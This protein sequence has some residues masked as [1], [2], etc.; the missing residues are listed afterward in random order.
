MEIPKEIE[1]TR[2]L[3]SSFNVFFREAD[4]W[5]NIERRD[6]YLQYVDSFLEMMSHEFR[7]DSKELP[8]YDE[9][10]NVISKW[11]SSLEKQEF[12]ES[13]GGGNLPWWHPEGDIEKNHEIV[14][15]LHLEK[16]AFDEFELESDGRFFCKCESPDVRRKIFSTFP[17]EML[18][19]VYCASKNIEW[20]PD[21][22]PK[23]RIS[24]EPEFESFLKR[25]LADSHLHQGVAIL[26]PKLFL[27][28]IRGIAPPPGF[29]TGTSRQAGN[30]DFAVPIIS[31]GATKMRIAPL[32]LACKVV[33]Q[34]LLLHADPN[35]NR[36]NSNLS[37]FWRE[38]DYPVL[39]HNNS[40]SSFWKNC[41]DYAMALGM[42]SKQSS[43]LVDYA[44]IRWKRLLKNSWIP[45]NKD[46]AFFKE[47]N[48]FGYLW[49]FM[50]RHVMKNPND[51]LLQYHYRQ[52]TRIVC[53]THLFFQHREGFYE[54]ERVRT[55]N[56]ALLDCVSLP[57][58]PSCYHPTAN[59]YTKM[60]LES[61]SKTENLKYAQLRMTLSTETPYSRSK[62]PQRSRPVVRYNALKT[63]LLSTL[64]SYKEYLS[65][66]CKKLDSKLDSN[67]IHIFSKPPVIG[68]F[69]IHFIR[70]KNNGVP[71]K[72]QKAD[73]VSLKK[74][75]AHPFGQLWQTSMKLA[76]I[77]I[78]Q[79]SLRCFFNRIDVAG[80]EDSMPNWVFSLVLREFNDRV[81]HSIGGSRVLDSNTRFPPLRFM[82]HAGEHFTSSIQGLRR[83]W[84]V[85]E[86]F[87]NIEFIGHALALS[88]ERYPREMPV[89]EYFD[90]ILW[91]LNILKEYCQE[92]TDLVSR[93]EAEVAKIYYEI[94]NNKKCP[95]DFH[96]L[97]EAYRARF[98]RDKMTQLGI[99]KE[100]THQKQRRYEYNYSGKMLNQEYHDNLNY[101]KGYIQ[102][103][104]RQSLIW[105]PEMEKPYPISKEFERDCLRPA[106]QNLVQV[107]K[108]KIKEKRIIIEHCP[109]SNLLVGHLGTYENHPIFDLDRPDGSGLP[110]TINTDDPAIFQTTLEEEYVHLWKIMDGKFALD[111]KQR[112]EWLD[113]VRKRGIETCCD[114]FFNMP[115]DLNFYRKLIQLLGDIV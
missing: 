64:K 51:C 5:E 14:P 53:A 58:R 87:P 18:Y 48:S 42:K 23:E 19:A 63:Q 74:M 22:E 114:H 30:T 101:Q 91:S 31:P 92:R 34:I 38:S 10:Q 100:I 97:W 115:Q 20:K 32:L 57:C 28:A 107:V 78:K 13:V 62:N 40:P 45:A 84:E 61:I 17:K 76:E 60:A 55:L 33:W 3:F 88:T 16:L 102:S 79:P 67:P 21:F 54:F 81:C 52:L 44:Y 65:D 46:S 110:V 68:I 25:G 82:S 90:D 29:S 89:S 12:R 106:Y 7:K 93:L 98:D 96:L 56:S 50:T 70:R 41:Y 71:L 49:W 47:T 43:K 24:R 35:V 27:E 111:P 104:L 9:I 85:V 105:N 75:F 37:Q 59:I 103:I 80:H 86:F 112:L 39:S 15:L 83:I 108:G 77:L 72:E 1:F 8:L 73:H 2:Y 4:C 36:D 94:Y 66:S 95:L 26:F 69:P 99:L 113:S 11:F 109:T 6:V